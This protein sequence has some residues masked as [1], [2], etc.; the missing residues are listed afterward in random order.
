MQDRVETETTP[1]G[2]GVAAS[3]MDATLSAESFQY[4][5]G[6]VGERAAIV[7]TPGKEYLVQTRL[8]PV[9]A[10]GGFASVE[11]LVRHAR[12]AGLAAEPLRVEIVEAL[13]TNETWFFRDL[14]PFEDLRRHVLPD[15]VERRRSERRLRIWSAACSSGQEPYSLVM[16]LREHFPALATWDVSIYGS[17]LSGEVLNLAREGRYSQFEVNRGLPATLLIKYFA[18]EGRAWQLKPEVRQAVRF[19]QMNLIGPWPTLPPMD[20]ILLRN[21]LIYFSDD[22]KRA[23]LRKMHERL[24]PDGYLFLG[25]SESIY[26]LSD[27]FGSVPFEKT[28]CYRPK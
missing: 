25:S 28:T 18:Q 27:D 24:R 13:T 17:D 19:F 26:K 2:E 10:R 23:I 1:R 14:N 4:V 12:Q 3:Q 21:V 9:A 6:L 20:L 5:A 15:L 7:L 8:A 16:L 22:T 11:A